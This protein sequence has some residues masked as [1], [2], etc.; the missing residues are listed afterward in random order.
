MTNTPKLP[1]GFK[2][3][4]GGDYAPDD[5]AGGGVLWEDG[6]RSA[7]VQASSKRWLKQST[8]G[9]NTI[10]YEPTSPITLDP[11]ARAAAARQLSE[12]MCWHWESAKPSA[13]R[14]IFKIVDAM[15]LSYEQ[16]RGER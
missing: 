3:W 4:H 12:N 11:A 6:G 2:P 7:R 9:G 16:A 13:R 1:E 8:A 5:Y 15:L 10:D 14:R